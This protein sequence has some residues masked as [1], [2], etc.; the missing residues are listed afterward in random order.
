MRERRNH[1]GMRQ[2]TLDQIADM[3]IS[4]RRLE[5]E[6]WG[7]RTLTTA[8]EERQLHRVRRGWYI[9]QTRW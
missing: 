5:D 6:G 4:R 1:L 8:I 7:S 3:L 2:A 9:E